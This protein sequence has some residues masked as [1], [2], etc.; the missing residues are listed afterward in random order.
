M[1]TI[2]KEESAVAHPTPTGNY[3]A[4]CYSVWDIG[5]QA[6]EWKGKKFQVPQLILGFEL[7]ERIES[8]DDANGKRYTIFKWYTRSLKDKAILRKDLISWRGKDFTSEELKGFDVDT[9]IGANC[10]LN[11]I[12]GPESGKPKAGAITAMPK[13]IPKITPE[14]SSEMPDWVK[15]KI[16][17]I[18]PDHTEP[19]SQETGEEDVEIP[20]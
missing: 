7:N 11:V 6:K 3:Q 13:G 18:A 9:V 17:S 20:F 4:V 16:G 10:F 2:V 14:N 5:L 15:K 1:S 12:L 19:V 8:D